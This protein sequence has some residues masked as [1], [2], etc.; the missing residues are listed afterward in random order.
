MRRNHN[1]YAVFKVTYYASE[2]ILN[3]Y[4][5]GHKQHWERAKHHNEFFHKLFEYITKKKFDDF[6]QEYMF[7]H[8]ECMLEELEQDY[9]VIRETHEGSYY[10][11]IPIENTTLINWINNNVAPSPC[12]RLIKPRLGY[13]RTVNNKRFERDKAKKHTEEFLHK[14]FIA[15][16]TRNVIIEKYKRGNSRK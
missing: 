6:I 15:E 8:Q 2:Y 13:D 7:L 11:L 10:Y 9:G 5:P 12:T 4:G 3:K 1:K 16:N 14:Q